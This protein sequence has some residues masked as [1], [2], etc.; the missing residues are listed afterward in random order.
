MISDTEIQELIVAYG[1]VAVELRPSVRTLVA[2][3]AAAYPVPAARPPLILI[4]GG[5]RESEP[6]A[7]AAPA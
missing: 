1:H 3:F 4:S 2:Q 5:K 7:N 6:A